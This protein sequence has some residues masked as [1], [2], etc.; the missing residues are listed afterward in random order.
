MNPHVRLLTALLP[1]LILVSACGSGQE[2]TTQLL[3]R[4]LQTQM[5]PDIAANRASVQPLPGGARVTL[6]GS[7]LFPNDT[8]TLDNQE[9]DPRAGVIEGLLDPD[10][11]QV[12]VADT[13]TLPDRQ[14]DTRVGNVV[15]YFTAY[16]LEATPR[17]ADPPQ[18][19]SAAATPAGLAITISVVCPNRHD[20]A[21]YDSGARKPECR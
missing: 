13:S 8:T 1:P 7:S 19:G 17:P 16:G 15:Q 6:L 11:M 2:R 4:R 5:A 20:R 14:R 18:P 12:Q 21:G 9:V 3:N 10:L